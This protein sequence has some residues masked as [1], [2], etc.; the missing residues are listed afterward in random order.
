[1]FALYIYSFFVL[2]INT[3]C[4]LWDNAYS[5]PVFGSLWLLIVDWL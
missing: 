3:G 5:A 1:M 2:T 4:L